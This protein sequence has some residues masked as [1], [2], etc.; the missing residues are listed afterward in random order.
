MAKKTIKK[1]ISKK[2]IK[3]SKSQSKRSTK[4][5]IVGKKKLQKLTDNKQKIITIAILITIAVIAWFL[6]GQNNLFIKEDN[7]AATVNGKAITTQQVSE[8]LVRIP[9]EYLAFV[10]ESV[11]LQQLIDEELLIQEA[12]S[13]DVTI[14]QSEVDQV[15]QVARQTSGFE[16]DEAFEAAL[17]DQNLSLEFLQDFYYKNLL[18]TKLL[19]KTLLPTIEV[20]AQE[21]QDFYTQ[22]AQQFLKDEQVKASHILICY[23]GALN[24]QSTISQVD[25]LAQINELKDEA[26]SENFAEL[27]KEHSTGPSGPNGGD[28]GFFGRGAMVPEFETT[29][30]ELEVG[31]VS[32]VVETQFGYHL[33]IVNDK[34]PA[35]LQALSE[36][37]D[38]IIEQVRAQKQQSEYTQYIEDLREK[39]TIKYGAQKTGQTD[40][41]IKITE[42]TTFEDTGEEICVDELGK[43]IVRLFST[44]WCPHCKWIQK[45]FDRTVS[46]YVD[47]G[48]ITAYHWELDTKDDTL[49]SIV[50]TTVSV[51]EQQLFQKYNP[52]GGV[53]TFVF[54][55]KY[56]RLGNGY[57]QQNDL[58]AEEAEFR[59]VIEKLLEN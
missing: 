8:Q 43:P 59:V 15:M 34:V 27:A 10:N 1:K 36:V 28:L 35:G 13:Q 41:T 44:T 42:I 9:P 51:E 46:E 53:P 24:C 21:I 31:E 5:K 54:G 40:D 49:T 20:T 18:F 29:A 12:A 22:N 37:Q 47:Q 4:T 14:S 6:L 32:D 39:A 2:T 45:T 48:L 58:D 38:F 30:F 7:V 19:N 16:T 23:E 50:E 11:V 17:K 55:C 57:E 56:I 52:R 25:A 26:T 33:I 3:K